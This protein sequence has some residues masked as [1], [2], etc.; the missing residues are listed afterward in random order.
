MTGAAKTTEKGIKYVGSTIEATMEKYGVK[1]KVIN[2]FR[3]YISNKS[4]RNINIM[5]EI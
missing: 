2:V 4:A 5:W 1:D 3:W